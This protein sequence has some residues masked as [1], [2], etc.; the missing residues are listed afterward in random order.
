[1]AGENNT[2]PAVSVVMPAYDEA[3]GVAAAVREVGTELDALGVD[4]ELLVVDDGSS[5]DTAEE[6]RRAGATVVSLPE[7]RGY[8]AAI[9]TGVQ[10]ARYDTILITDADGTYPAAAIPDMLDFARSYDMVVGAR[11]GAEVSIPALRRPAKWF[12]RRL[13]SY[14]TGRKIPD[15]NSGL[16]VFK[17]DLVD[18]FSHV[19]PLGFSFTTSITLAALSSGALVYYHPIDYRPRVGR[20]KIQPV[21]ALDFLVLV[22]R[23]MVYFNPLKVFVPLGAGLFLAGLAKLAYDLTRS[24]VS[25]SA[26]M[27]FLGAAIVWAVGL[28]SDQIARM[29]A[30][31]WIR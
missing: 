19:L 28:L 30:R 22:I 15:L 8:G 17:R 21:H 26:V 1:M 27:C 29:G 6:A 7:N 20:S 25:D 12:L 11:V 13:A 5:D 31:T 9:K 3:R 4:Y 16:R 24:N 10:R 18:R 23:S 14:L 2:L